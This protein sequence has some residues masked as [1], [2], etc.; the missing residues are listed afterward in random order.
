M[1]TPHP[2]LAKPVRSM[3]CCCCGAYIKGR[4]FHNQ[5]T[6]FGL[7]DCC[8]EFVSK[9]TEDVERTYGVPGVHYRLEAVAKPLEAQRK[10]PAN[11]RHEGDI[12]GCGS[13]NVSEPDKEG[14]CDCYNCG[15]FF[16]ADDPAAQVG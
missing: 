12:V 9:R 15:I 5:D 14:V 6:G 7:G 10:C 11:E 4:Q 1:N 3:T 16:G 2:D 13:T 8:V